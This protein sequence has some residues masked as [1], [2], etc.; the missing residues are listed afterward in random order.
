MNGQTVITG[1]L[2]A[3]SQVVTEKKSQSVVEDKT[4]DLNTCCHS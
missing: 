4:A 1:H 3:L 2:D